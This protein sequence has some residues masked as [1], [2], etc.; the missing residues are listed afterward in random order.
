MQNANFL[1][2]AN[3]SNQIENH[4]CKSN[5]LQAPTFHQPLLLV[6]QLGRY[7]LFCGRKEIAKLLWKQAE[8]LEY[9]LQVEVLEYKSGPDKGKRYVQVVIAG[10]KTHYIH[11][12]KPFFKNYYHSSL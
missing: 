3:L 8:V 1:H 4:I 2:G 10:D 6:F 5:L 7:F 11:L 12:G 9:F